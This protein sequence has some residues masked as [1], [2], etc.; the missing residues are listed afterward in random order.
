[1][2]GKQKMVRKGRHKLLFDMMGRGELY[3]HRRHPRNWY[4]E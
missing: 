3:E 1:M 2:S 4:R